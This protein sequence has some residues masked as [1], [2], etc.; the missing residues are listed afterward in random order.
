MVITANKQSVGH[1]SKRCKKPAESD[2][3]SGFGGGDAE[4]PMTEDTQT[5][6]YGQENAEAGNDGGWSSGAG[7][8]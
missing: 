7:A 1:T 6:G 3:Y 5:R 4:V 8:W 2:E